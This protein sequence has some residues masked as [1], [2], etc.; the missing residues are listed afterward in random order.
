MLDRSAASVAP[1]ASCPIRTCP[2]TPR[3]RMLPVDNHSPWHE[4]LSEARVEFDNISNTLREHLSQSACDP[5]FHVRLGQLL[6]EITELT[7]TLSQLLATELPRVD[8][9]H[10]SAR[11]HLDAARWVAEGPSDDDRRTA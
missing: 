11:S 10:V 9:T 1:G 7:A 5:R 6:N 8:W 3:S 2:G 4:I